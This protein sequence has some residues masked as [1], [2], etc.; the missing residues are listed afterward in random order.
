MVRLRINF[1]H[2]DADPD[3]VGL[4]Q[5][6]LNAF[7]FF[8]N[9]LVRTGGIG[10]FVAPDPTDPIGSGTANNVR[11]LTAATK[12]AQAGW[13]AEVHSL[14]PTDF[15]AEIDGFALVDAQYPI[16]NLRWVVA[17]VPAITE[18]YVNKLKALGG[19]INS[20]RFPLL[21]RH[22]HGGRT[23][24]PD[25]AGQR[26]PARHELR[27]HADRADEPMGARVLRDH[28]QE[29]AGHAHQ[30]G[31]NARPATNGWRLYTAA[32]GWFLGEEDTLGAL[33]PGKYADLAVL[34]AD[35]FDA[36][37]VPDEEIKKMRSVLTLVGGEIVHGDAARL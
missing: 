19:G 17:H 24:V 36:R 9:D 22:P 15:K 2:M 37:A 5:R 25:A 20:H 13:R 29:R 34:S 12:V 3:S 18:D 1:L 6:L 31:T 16:T 23:A 33:E 21:R 32:N 30:R 14:T 35:Y 8:G 27:R 10:E 28:R 7:P 11:W 26:D 4:S